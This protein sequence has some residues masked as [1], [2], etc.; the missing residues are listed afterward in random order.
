[1][2]QRQLLHH[3]TQHLNFLMMKNILLY[4]DTRQ[5]K[6]NKHALIAM[7]IQ[8][9]YIFN[10]CKIQDALICKQCNQIQETELNSTSTV[11]KVNKILEFS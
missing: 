10:L 4:R 7:I 5:S 3:N 1:M 9:S 6:I 11:D 8:F 2:F